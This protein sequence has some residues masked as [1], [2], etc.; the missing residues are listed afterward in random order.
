MNMHIPNVLPAMG[1]LQVSNHLLGDQKALAEA[2]DRDGYWFFRDVLDKGVIARIRD[3]YANYLADMGLVDRDDPEARYNG[4]DYAHL[5]INTNISRLNDE[6]VHKLLH[7]AP[8]INAFFAKLFGCEPFWVPFTVHRAN[9]PVQ[10]KT[11]SR[12]DFIHEDGVYNDGLSFLICWVPLDDID[13]DVG[14][15]ALLEGVHDGP[16]LHRKDGLNVIPIKL[17]DVPEGKWRRAHYRPGD[18]LLMGLHTPHSGLANIS[19]DRFR[20]SMDT[21]VMPSTGKVPLIG[22]IVDISATGVTLRTAQGDRKLRF[23]A[24]TFVRGHNGRQV[25]VDVA[26]TMYGPGD[27]VIIAYEGDLALNMRPPT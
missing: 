27:E 25:E 18:V 16:C 8:E 10:D 21:R 13:E 19:K 6:K 4:A 11:R 26:P 2:W 5:P 1:E 9:P 12:F 22:E 23:D 20:F 3:V 7:E 24:T 14:G 17:E 15:L